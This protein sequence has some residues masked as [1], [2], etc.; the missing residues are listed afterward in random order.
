MGPSLSAV[1]I[2]KEQNVRTQFELDL[3]QSRPS[4]FTENM[5]IWSWHRKQRS[6]CKVKCISRAT[7]CDRRKRERTKRWHTSEHPQVLEIK[8]QAKRLRVSIT[9]LDQK[10]SNLPEIQFELQTLQ[11]TVE[12][13]TQVL[14][15]GEGKLIETKVMLET[16]SLPV[17]LIK[18]PFLTREPI[19][20]NVTSL[21]ISNVIV[22]FIIGFALVIVRTTFEKVSSQEEVR[23][24]ISPPI[25]GE[26]PHS[27]LSSKRARLLA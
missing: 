6:K 15:A 22:G 12:G 9:E 23:N 14:T 5:E 21:V 19:S 25:M 17:R 13:L 16:V 8:E 4:L 7:G 18:P 24:M 20:P 26:V 2:L 10:L 3:G 1:N 11:K 27:R